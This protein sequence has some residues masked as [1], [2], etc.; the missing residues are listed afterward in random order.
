LANSTPYNIQVLTVGGMPLADITDRELKEHLLDD[1]DIEMKE[2]EVQKLLAEANF[3]GGSLEK[4]G[5][6]LLVS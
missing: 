4:D 6:E 1:E 2:A 5:K 3:G